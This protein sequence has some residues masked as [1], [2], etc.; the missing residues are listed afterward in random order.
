MQCVSNFPLNSQFKQNSFATSKGQTKTGEE[1]KFH[2]CGC[3]SLSFVVHARLLGVSAVTSKEIATV[4]GKICNCTREIEGAFISHR[5]GDKLWATAERIVARL[6]ASLKKISTRKEAHA[7]RR[8][9]PCACAS[10]PPCAFSLLMER[11]REGRI[12]G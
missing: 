4:R 7:D 3:A 11:H 8:Q 12:A 9:K 10:S 2:V 6:I 5:M 1:R